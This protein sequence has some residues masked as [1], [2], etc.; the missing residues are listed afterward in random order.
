MANSTFISMKI[1]KIIHK[2]IVLNSIIILLVITCGSTI[3]SLSGVEIVSKATQVRFGE[4]S[5]G[6][7]KMTIVRPKWTRTIEMKM[8]S[9][10]SDLSMVL[11]TAPAKEKGQVFLKRKTEMW[12][13]IPSISRMVKL[14]PSMLSQGWMGSDYTNDDMMNE[15]ALVKDYKHNLKGTELYDG[16]E[17]YKIESI[18]YENASS[19]WGKLIMWISKSDF[20][21]LK[22]ESYDED[23]SLVKTEFASDIKK[24]DDRMLPTKFTILPADEKGNKTIVEIVEMSFS[25]SLSEQFF[26]Q[27]NMKNIR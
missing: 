6:K 5:V 23:M 19:I 17:C 25:Q 18:P 13:W 15:N 1:S 4:N 11:I 8:W 14:P 9:K 22:T 16:K 12:N 24:M 27:Q 10:G 7:M 21:I 26:S 3:P 2:L 20:F